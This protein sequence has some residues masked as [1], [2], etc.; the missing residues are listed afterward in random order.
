MADYSQTC[1]EYCIV[2]GQKKQGIEYG[3][4]KTKKL[5]MEAVFYEVKED[6]SHNR[7]DV[8]KV[9][10]ISVSG[11][12]IDSH[13]FQVYGGYPETVGICSGTEHHESM[14][15]GVTDISLSGPQICRNKYYVVW[16]IILPN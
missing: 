8:K 5:R 7:A 12:K 2:K 4:F 15:A 13:D 10:G 16:L 3:N 9:S 6:E 1:D 11:G 14:D